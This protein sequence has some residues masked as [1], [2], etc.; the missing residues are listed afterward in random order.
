MRLIQAVTEFDLSLLGQVS[1][2]TRRWHWRNHNGRFAGHLAPLVLFFGPEADIGSID[3]SAL[4]RWRQ[5]LI[6]TREL[7]AYS[8]RNYTRSLRQFFGFLA[9]E[10]HIGSNPAM[11]LKMPPLPDEPPKEI[12]LEDAQKI[13]DLVRVYS[14]RDY[15]A[16][17]LVAQTE[18]RYREVYHLLLGD[19]DLRRGVVIARH[20][21]T[22]AHSLPHSARVALGR[23]LELRAHLPLSKKDAP[24]NLFVGRLPLLTEM[25]WGGVVF[26]V[27]NEAFVQVLASTAA[28][29]S[30][31][32]NLKVSDVDL[33]NKTAI[34]REKGRGGLKKARYVFLDNYATEAVRLWLSV[35]PAADADWL[36]LNNEGG[37]VQRRSWQRLLAT[38]ADAAGVEGR[39]NAHSWRHGWAMQA[40]RNGADLQT[41]SQVLGHTTIRVTSEF[42]ARW[43]YGELQKRHQAFSWTARR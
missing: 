40:L 32:L 6:E 29:I 31:V 19:V 8:L 35:R 4:R 11:R 26:G 36:F 2:E 41:V 24:E 13:L 33:P 25:C 18:M 16:H 34:V 22:K 38:F 3:A 17:L 42:Y 21:S 43:Q 39:S 23:Y 12:S 15:A 5:N 37:R 28:R 30:G 9:N 14:A 1:D 20:K 27:R 10:G 7:G